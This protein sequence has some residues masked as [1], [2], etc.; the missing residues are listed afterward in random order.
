MHS[1]LAYLTAFSAYLANLES[2]IHRLTHTS[3]L[4]YLAYLTAF[5]AYLAYLES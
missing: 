4:A 3:L 1:Y 5:S 2:L